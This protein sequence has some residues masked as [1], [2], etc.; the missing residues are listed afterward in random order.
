[1]DDI[2]TLILLPLVRHILTAVFGYMA[3]KGWY[4][5]DQSTN[6]VEVLGVP[7]VGFLVTVGWSLWQKFNASKLVQAALAAP[8][9]T[10]LVFV[11]KD[12]GV[13]TLAIFLA[14]PLLALTAQGC[15]GVKAPAQLTPVG[16]TAWYAGKVIAVV[17]TLQGIAKDGESA[18]V[19]QRNDA[20]KI[21][22]ATK[23]AGQGGVE[24]SNVL[25]AGNDSAGVARA[26][27][28]IRKAL[29]D[30]PD[31]LSPSAAA[32]VRPYVQTALTLLTI[33]G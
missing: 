25:R 12:A 6:L 31:Q 19:I 29:L 11:K 10:P 21:V 28:I 16:D 33:F 14:L 4:T 23:V 9:G 7:I 24:L 30:L 18:G 8:P 27:A 32:V 5:S 26:V 15:A 2:G 20:V 17:D 3:L 22:T 13:K 1:M